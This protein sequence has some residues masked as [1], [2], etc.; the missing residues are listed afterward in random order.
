[1]VYG[2]VF[3]KNNNKGFSLI[4]LIVVVAIMAILLTVT[5]GN[6]SKAYN[7]DALS[8]GSN[9]ASE[10]RSSRTVAMG[11]MDSCIKIFKDSKGQVCVEAFESDYDAASKNYTGLVSKGITVVGKSGITVQYR[12]TGDP[13]GTYSTLGDSDSLIVVF[14][15]GNGSLKDLKA[16][17]KFSAP[18]DSDEGKYYEEIK[19]SKSNRDSVISFNYLTGKVDLK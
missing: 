4:E 10:I 11:K 6:L 15:R 3:M 5:V 7:K 19:L 16:S 1:M 12:V 18:V 2:N 8:C 14:D 17:A 13:A 9:L